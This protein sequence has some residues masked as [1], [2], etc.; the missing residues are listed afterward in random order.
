MAIYFISDLHL[1]SE[2][3]EITQVFLRFLETQAKEADALYILGDLFETW[4]GEDNTN[5]YQS[6]ILNALKQFNINNQ[7]PIFFM[8]GNRDFLLSQSVLEK[9]HCQLLADPSLILIDEK[10]V[11]L[12]HGDKLCTLDKSYQRYR[13]IVQH[14][15]TK[16]LFLKLPLSWRKKIAAFLR[17][18]S[19]L[20]SKSS[21]K[22]KLPRYFD[23]ALSAV[24]AL[25]REKNATTLIHGHTHQPYIHFFVLDNQPATRIVLG[26]W[27]KTGSVLIYEEN[28]PKLQEVL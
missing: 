6:E 28:G 26:D 3:P 2:E 22:R 17:S 16:K 19:H 4:I 20:P 13:K 8:P 24:Y 9:N 25:M 11:I 23:V 10:P 12:T 15:T 5:H 7:V 14:P 21:E 1:C 27:G 18:R